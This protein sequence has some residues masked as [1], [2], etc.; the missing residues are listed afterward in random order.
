M[1]SMWGATAAGAGQGIDDLMMQMLREAQQEETVRHNKAS[2]GLQGQQIA[3]SAASRRYQ[4]DLTREN[5]LRLDADRDAARIKNRTTIRPAGSPVTPK[6]REEELAAGATSEASYKTDLE[7]TMGIQP[8]Q[9]GGEV[10]VFDMDSIQ[11]ADPTYT[12]NETE[13]QRRTRV[14]DEANKVRQQELDEYRRSQ[15]DIGR[16]REQRLE[17]YGPPVVIIGDPNIPGGSR[18]VPRGEV[19]EGGTGAPLAAA[20]RQRVDAY[21]NTLDT[22]DRIIQLGEAVDWKGIGP[23]E[24]RVGSAAMSWFGA[25]DPREEELRNAL[26]QLT[27]QAS[28]QE[29]GKQF[30]GS[31]KTMLDEFLASYK[32]NPRAALTRLRQFQTSGRQMLSNMGVGASTG[33]PGG[34]PDDPAGLF[35]K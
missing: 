2:E 25:G 31:E 1:P 22:V 6:E 18:V 32:Q 24:G 20:D 34:N 17:S 4:S 8:A 12:A 35:S 19:P 15:L 29:G 27:A 33:A 28:F 13:A 21:K 5:Q 9:P 23:I 14:D 10:N 11:A 7:D 26:A 16:N 3:E 30:T